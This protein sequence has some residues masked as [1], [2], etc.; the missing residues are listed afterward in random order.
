MAVERAPLRSNCPPSFRHL[1]VANDRATVSST[2]KKDKRT[3]HMMNPLKR[4]HGGEKLG[5]HS[6]GMLLLA[7]ACS[8]LTTLLLLRIAINDNDPVTPRVMVQ[9][10]IWVSESNCVDRRP[11]D[12]SGIGAWSLRKRVR[13]GR[14]AAKQSRQ[15]SPNETNHNGIRTSPIPKRQ[16]VICTRVR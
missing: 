16:F 13:D 14:I 5:H 10:N 2:C 4:I 8:V 12:R 7:I 9:K 3:N 1:L 6:L 15:E 11:N